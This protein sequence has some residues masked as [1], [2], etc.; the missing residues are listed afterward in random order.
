MPLINKKTQ[1]NY[2]INQFF[3]DADHKKISIQFFGVVLNSEKRFIPVQKTALIMNKDE[4]I[5]DPTFQPEKD[6]KFDLHDEKTWGGKVPSQFPYIID[7]SKQSFDLLAQHDLN[8]IKGY[9][10]IKQLMYSLLQKT[11]ELPVGPDW[12]LV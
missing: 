4:K 9:E 12:E 11:G 2:E 7:Q 1:E 10:A 8:N 6:K 3:F 5:I